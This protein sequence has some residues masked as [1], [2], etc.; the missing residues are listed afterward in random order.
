MPN[1]LVARRA[2]AAPKTKQ[3]LE[4]GPWLPATVGPEDELIEVDL[5]LPA[6][7]SVVSAHKPVL[8]VADHPVGKRDDGL[9]A[10]PQPEPGRL[11]S[12]DVLVAGS[13]EPFEALEAVRIDRGTHGEVSGHEVQHGCPGE[14]GNDLHTHAARC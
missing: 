6:A 5:E 8:E 13:G 10:L 11:G 4:G 3:R 9:G 14:V 7:H 2:S 12:W 1:L